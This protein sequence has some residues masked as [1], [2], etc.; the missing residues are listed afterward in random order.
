MFDSQ[1]GG[2]RWRTLM[3]GLGSFAVA[4]FFIVTI[5]VATAQQRVARAL[6]SQ[7]VGYDYN[8]AIRYY[9]KPDEL[10]R[11]S[12]DHSRTLIEQRAR[13][14]DL[15]GKKTQLDRSLERQAVILRTRLTSIGSNECSLSTL[16]DDA[17][18][19]IAAV[20]SAQE[21]LAS[22]GGDSN[23]ILKRLVDAAEAEAAQADKIMDELDVN[24]GETGHQQEHIASLEETQESF[25]QQ[26]ESIAK[27]SNIMAVL[28][29]F[30]QKCVWQIGCW[31]APE[32]SS[33]CRRP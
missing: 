10:T 25:K 16:T 2:N 5:L 12:L 6:E 15:E 24:R 27:S 14:R 3:R 20:P 8:V 18:S 1:T 19:L 30:R 28:D 23:P 13:L 9:F 22:R 33:T 4:Y 29:L 31:P 26:L 21:C 17:A 32:S 7:N 11:K